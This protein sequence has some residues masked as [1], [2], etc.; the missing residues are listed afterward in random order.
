MDIGN[1]AFDLLYLAVILSVIAISCLCFP[2]LAAQ[3]NGLYSARDYRNMGRWLVA[4]SVLV[5]VA[6]AVIFLLSLVA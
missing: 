3:M 5:A 6:S 1:Y 2:E 4:G